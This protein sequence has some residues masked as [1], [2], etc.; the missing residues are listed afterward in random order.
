MGFYIYSSEQ[1]YV[2]TIDQPNYPCFCIW[3]IFASH[4]LQR[5]NNLGKS[6]NHKSDIHYL[7]HLPAARALD[8]KLA[9]ERMVKDSQFSWFHNK[10]LT[11]SNLTTLALRTYKT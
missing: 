5:V 2:H 1:L 9:L 10:P 3:S 6:Y 8:V 7:L 4:Q 11:M